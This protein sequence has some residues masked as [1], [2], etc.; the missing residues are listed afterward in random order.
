MQQIHHYTLP[1]E[2]TFVQYIYGSGAAKGACYDIRTKW[3][4]PLLI[5]PLDKFLKPHS[6]QKE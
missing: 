5:L 2:G 6:L 1:I 4:K 3:D